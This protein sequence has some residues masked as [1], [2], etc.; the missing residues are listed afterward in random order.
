MNIVDKIKYLQK[1]QEGRISLNAIEKNLGFGKSVIT[2]WENRNPSIDKISKIADYFG[3]SVD[4]LLDRDKTFSAAVTDE[5]IL[6][7][8]YRGCDEKHKSAILCYAIEQRQ[9]CELHLSNKEKGGD[10]SK[11]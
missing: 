4:Y 10:C 8:S 9:L 1:R 5:E 6:I 2:S 11:R 7:E 3:V